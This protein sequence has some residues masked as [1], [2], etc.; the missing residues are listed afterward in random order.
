MGGAYSTHGTGEM[1]TVFWL[2][3]LKGR[4]HSEDM[5]RCEDNIRMDLKQGGCSVYRSHM[6]GFFA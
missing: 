1:R 6:P 4:D 5:R 2:E 3:N